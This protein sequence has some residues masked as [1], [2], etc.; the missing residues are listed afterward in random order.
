M[1][2][3]RHGAFKVTPCPECSQEGLDKSVLWP[4]VTGTDSANSEQLILDLIQKKPKVDLINKIIEE[5]R[6][7]LAKLEDAGLKHDSEKPDLSLLPREFLEEVARA[8][9]HGEKKYGRYNYL[10]GLSWNRV[11]AASLR[12]ITAFNDGEDADPESGLSHLSHAGACIAMLLVY[13]KRGLGTD[14]RYKDTKV[15]SK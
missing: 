7:T 10:N 2:C 13:Y 6:D 12:H 1:I 9:Q 5:H 15:D 11:V 4:H 14:T 8:F 3:S